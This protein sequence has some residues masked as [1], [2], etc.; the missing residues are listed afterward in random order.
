MKVLFLSSVPQCGPCFSVAGVICSVHYYN[1][2][3][4][5]P[6]QHHCLISI[7]ITGLLLLFPRWRYTFQR[8]PHLPR[9]LSMLLTEMEKNTLVCLR[10]TQQLTRWCFLDAA[11]RNDESSRPAGSKELLLLYQLFTCNK[12]YSHMR[13]WTYLC[14]PRFQRAKDF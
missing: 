12:K 10:L 3:R 11:I 6:L 1:D 8:Q 4:I 13:K 7:I 9:T 14:T 2:S 5:W